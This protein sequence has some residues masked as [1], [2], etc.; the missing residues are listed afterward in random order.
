MLLTHSPAKGIESSLEKKLHSIFTGT[1]HVP[2]IARVLGAQTSVPFSG[3]SVQWGTVGT[4]SVW[5]T[6]D[7]LGGECQRRLPTPVMLQLRARA[8]R[9]K[10]L[11]GGSL[12]DAVHQPAAEIT[13]KSNCQIPACST[14]ACLWSMYSQH[15]ASSRCQRETAPRTRGGDSR[16]EG[17]A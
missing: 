14:E 17:T 16:C 4:T 9:K 1:H 7:W 6:R 11:L 10:P 13:P 5:V 2:G 12:Q 15:W 3:T 8:L